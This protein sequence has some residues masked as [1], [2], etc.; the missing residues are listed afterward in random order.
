MLKS[1][2]NSINK[3]NQNDLKPQ[4]QMEAKN[5]NTLNLVE[6]LIESND[7]HNIFNSNKNYILKSDICQSEL[8]DIN[9]INFGKLNNN[10]PF[11]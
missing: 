10:N 6:N 11:S 7:N 2:K 1:N 3:E 9:N 8:N 5:L 4:I